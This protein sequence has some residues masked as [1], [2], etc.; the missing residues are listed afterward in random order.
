VAL[1]H[2][3]DPTAIDVDMVRENIVEGARQSPLLGNRRTF[4]LPGVERLNLASANA[5]LKVLEEPPPGTY[6][7]MTT[8]NAGGLLRTIRSRAQ[9]IR[10]QPLSPTDIEQV[11]VHNGVDVTDARRRA[12]AAPGSH[13]G[14]WDDLDEIPLADLLALCRDGFTSKGVQA[15]HDALPTKAD[16]AHGRT[17]AQEQRREL[18][19]WLAALAQ[20]L[21]ADL[22]QPAR[23]TAAATTIERIQQLQHDLRLNLAPRLVIEALAI[24]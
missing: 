2:D 16:E 1:P 12:L 8:A 19:R 20:A 18:S 4:F 11:L 15:V 5:L 10:L 21:R 7:I 23:A 13:R 24:G 14:L 9:L 3:S 6:L 22:R 17:L